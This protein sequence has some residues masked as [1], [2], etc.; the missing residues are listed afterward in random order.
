MVVTNF[1]A[2]LVH[3]VQGIK[4]KKIVNINE[5]QK[6]INDLIYV[7]N[8]SL[9]TYNNFCIVGNTVTKHLF[10]KGRSS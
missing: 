7:Y 1:V 2:S 5:I 3:T 10:T 8:I 4:T 9:Q 6:M